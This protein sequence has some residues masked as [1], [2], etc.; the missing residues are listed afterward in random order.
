MNL[1]EVLADGIMVLH[2]AFVVSLFLGLALIITGLL[3]GWA[4]IHHPVF[5]TVHLAATLFILFRVGWD[6]PCPLTVAEDH[7]RAPAG[8]VCPLDEGFHEF[9]HRLA[10]RGIPAHAFAVQATASGLLALGVHAIAY[11]SRHRRGMTC[12]R[13]S[14]KWRVMPAFSV[15]VAAVEAVLNPLAGLDRST[16]GGVC[17]STTERTGRLPE[18]IQ[19]TGPKETAHGSGSRRAG[20]GPEPPRAFES[21]S[22]RPPGNGL[23]RRR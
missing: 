18:T 2:A 12:G 17:F 21:G 22:L 16:A 13:E 8:G 1:R 23:S 6:I 9:F 5:R 11:K 7:V 19:V 3:L 20:R 10:L 14:G 15:P 4:W